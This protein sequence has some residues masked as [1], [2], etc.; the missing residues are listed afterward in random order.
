MGRSLLSSNHWVS[1]RA[2]TPFLFALLQTC[3]EVGR[4][5]Q[6]CASDKPSFLTSVKHILNCPDLVL[7]CYC[8]SGLAVEDV[9][10]AKLV[11][12]RFGEQQK[13]QQ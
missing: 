6:A 13:S 7:L 5:R 11:Y 1:I 9:V 8:T 2:Y 4:F 3:L 12:D 10:S